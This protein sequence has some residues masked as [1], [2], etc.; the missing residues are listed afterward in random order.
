[1]IK[2]VFGVIITIFILMVVAF[3]ILVS[4]SAG[5]SMSLQLAKKFIPGKLNYSTVYGTSK[6]AVTVVQF[7]YYYQGV[8][9]SI[10]KLHLNWHPI[11]LL[12]GTLYI[13]H[14]NA[15]NIKIILLP[16]PE[17]KNKKEK[18]NPLLHQRFPLSLEIEE[19]YLE[20]IRIDQKTETHPVLVRNLRLKQINISYSLA[21]TIDAKII[22]PFIINL[23]LSSTGT[24]DNYHFFLTAK[25]NADL[26]WLIDGKGTRQWIELK[27]HEAH[28]LDGHLNAFMKI[29]FE[30]LLKWQINTD[31]A[32]LNLRRFYK[33]WPRKLTFQLNTT[34][35]C[36]INQFFN[37]TISGLLQT[38][39]TY[40]HITGQHT[41]AWDLNWSVDIGDFSRLLTTASGTLKGFG[42]ITGPT[43]SP[44]ITGDL[45]GK[46]I[47]LFNCYV[48]ALKSH[49]CFDTS[50]NQDSKA[51]FNFHHLTI[52]FF[53]LSR[54]EINASGE[55][56]AHQIS[57]KMLIDDTKSGKIA[58]NSLFHENFEDKIWCGTFTR[59]SIYSEKFGKWNIDQ[60]AT[61]IID[62]NH[63]TL[64]PLCL[65]SRNGHLCLCGEWGKRSFSVAD[66]KIT[67][68]SADLAFLRTILPEI[69][70]P[71]RCLKSNLNIRGALKKPAPTDILELKQDHVEC[72]VVKTASIRIQAFVNVTTSRINYRFY[73]YSQNQPVQIIGQTRLD[74]PGYPTTFTLQGKNILLMNTRQYV[75]Y[76]T[77]NL[78]IDILGRS[79]N[80]TG[81][82][83][84]P[85]AILKPTTFNRST[86]ITQDVVY[87]GPEAQKRSPWQTHMNIK[88]MLGDQIFLE[89][90]GIKGRFTGELTLLKIPTQPLIANGRIIIVDGTFTTHGRTLDIT[91]HS[92]VSFIRN[93]V[94]NPLLNVRAIRT[95][96]SLPVSPEISN[97]I[98]TV[99][100]DIEGTLHNPE[101]GLYAS[102][103]NLTQ[104]D[105]SSY[106]IFGHPVNANT[107]DNVNL[108]VDAIDTLNIF[109]N[110]KSMRSIIDEIT[111][112][113]GLT[114]LGIESRTTALVL[115]TP[116]NHTQSAFVIGR[117][118]SPHI[119]IRY[120]RGI[121]IPINIVQL[122]YLINKNWSIQTEVSSE[123]SGG[124]VLY[125]L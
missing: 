98:I 1:M 26:H 17:K 110:Q 48:A 115:S 19:G 40:F 55:S 42:S 108:L 107:L 43:Q 113:L 100:L 24:R 61:V 63:T 4:T 79:I 83:T 28:T 87:V 119:Y 16:S 62:S 7:D 46:N 123:G 45:S 111:Q 78:R 70:Q 13:T 6:G 106:L 52:P 67:I 2:R 125:T 64:F 5:L 59:F 27:M 38:S 15:E 12:R 71:H 23:H 18:I 68:N 44:L 85:K 53:Q 124:D 101:I 112:G 22:Q 33:K 3:S 74:L 114:E 89:S 118:L 99:G 36:K 47:K 80:I 96:K 91:P 31:V 66:I 9:I 57:I 84:I 65:H 58:L 49:W 97:Q 25:K 10:D 50:F 41:Q 104:A 56:H 82:L 109:G 37:F 116:N 14:L 86:A 95:L 122:R 69:I 8:E 120:S 51:K 39:K 121:T 34:G 11:A 35:C 75:I 29:N 73:G 60:P 93:P 90:L 77:A 21:S 92:S 76:G 81:I 20:N 94:N 30:P 103:P 117:Y 88:I 72:P 32:H 54:L 105:I 102:D